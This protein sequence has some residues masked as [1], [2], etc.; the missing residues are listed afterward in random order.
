MGNRFHKNL[1]VGSFYFRNLKHVEI[2]F[3]RKRVNFCIWPLPPPKQRPSGLWILEMIYFKWMEKLLF[4]NEAQDKRPLQQVLVAV[5]A[6]LMPRLHDLEDW[7]MLRCQG[8]RDAIWSLLK[9]P[10]G[11]SQLRP[12]EFW[13]KALSPSA[14]NYFHFEKQFLAYSWAS[15]ETDTQPCATQ[16]PC[17]LRIPS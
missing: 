11:E 14:D 3:L 7:T 15:V 10:I 12:L 5:Q 8:Q 2:F 13:S 16:V 9:T 17:N 1:G 6:T 4:L